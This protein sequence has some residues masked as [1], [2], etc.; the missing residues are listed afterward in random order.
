MYNMIQKF[1]HTDKWWGKGI[2]LILI[3]M[4]F[5]CVFYGSWLLISKDWGTAEYDI[6]NIPISLIFLFL[7]II[8]PILSFFFFPK[9]FKKMSYIKHPYLINSIFIFLSLVLFIF[10]ETLISLRLF[11]DTML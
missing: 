3:Y 5:W 9:L 10:F 11:F 6:Y 1:F 4:I 2:F 8:L 7:Y